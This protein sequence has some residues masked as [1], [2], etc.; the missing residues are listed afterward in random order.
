MLYNL[1]KCRN[2]VLFND[3]YIW[4]IKTPE[5][6]V[7]QR[8]ASLPIMTDAF[9]LCDLARTLNWRAVVLNSCHFILM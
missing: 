2:A 6:S 7:T 3:N 5:R 9:S 8:S 1:F 4:A